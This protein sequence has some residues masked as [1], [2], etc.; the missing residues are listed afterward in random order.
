MYA[1]NNTDFW[2][3]ASKLLLTLLPIEQEPRD[4]ITLSIDATS[5]ALKIQ[6]LIQVNSPEVALIRTVAVHNNLERVVAFP[7]KIQ[8]EYKVIFRLLGGNIPSFCD[9]LGI[10]MFSND[11]IP[12]DPI[13]I[14]QMEKWHGQVL[15]ERNLTKI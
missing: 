1:N 13:Y 5:I 6:E 7:C 2:A 11:N 4:I 8:G 14:A 12:F 15:Y 10:L 9:R 3:N